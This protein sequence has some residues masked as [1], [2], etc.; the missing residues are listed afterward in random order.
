MPLQT[1]HFKKKITLQ[2]AKY[3]KPKCYNKPNKQAKSLQQAK[4]NKPNVYNKP[5]FG[6]LWGNLAC[7]GLL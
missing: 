5:N 2:Q 3:N 1:A 4:Y 6:L 7:C